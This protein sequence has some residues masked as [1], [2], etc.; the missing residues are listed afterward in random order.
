MS[1]LN[2]ALIVFPTLV[3]LGLMAINKIEFGEWRPWQALLE[4]VVLAVFMAYFY[5]LFVMVL[6]L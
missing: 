4:T 5:A 2:F 6:S 3:F 1:I